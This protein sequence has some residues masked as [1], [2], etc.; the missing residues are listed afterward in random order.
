MYKRQTHT[1]PEFNDW[2]IEAWE[3]TTREL[4]LPFDRAIERGEI[5]IAVD[6]SALVEMLVS[7][8]V[9]RS[10]LMKERIGLGDAKRLANQ[11]LRFARARP[12]K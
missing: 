8:M 7:P 2:Q 5:S 6:V 1:D 4:S 9:V 10:V 11:V 12:G 3:Q